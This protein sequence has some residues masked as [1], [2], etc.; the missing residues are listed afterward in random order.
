MNKFKQ[1]LYDYFHQPNIVKRLII[2]FIGVFF[3]GFFLSFL[4]NVNLGTD[5]YTFMNFTISGKIHWQFGTWQLLLNLL[6]FLLMLWKGRHLIGLG[7][8]A[9]MVLI[10]YVSDFF[11]WVWSICIPDAYFTEAPGRYLIFGAALLLFVVSAAFYMN[12]DVGISPYDAIP[13]MINEHLPKLPYFIIRIAW[14]YLAVLI[15]Y[16]CGGKAGIGVLIM[17]VALGPVVSLVGKIFD[18]LFHSPAHNSES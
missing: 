13:K 6:M 3:M 18:P 5:P 2:M 9:N 8:L 1:Y 16:L 17:A 11:R 15:G 7:T 10:G 12:S 4:L 14:D